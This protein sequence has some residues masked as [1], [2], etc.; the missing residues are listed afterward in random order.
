M[1]HEVTS[2]EK[3]CFITLTYDDENLPLR[4]NDPR[5]ILVKSDLQKFF[6]RMRKDLEFTYYACGEYGD[7]GSRPHF[8][9]IIFGQW[10]TK[11]QLAKY[12]RL[13]LVDV[14]TATEKSIRY[15]AGYVSKKLGLY[16]YSENERPAP[17]QISSQG[18]GF[19]WAKENLIESLAEGCITYQGSKLP[20][21]RPYVKMYEELFPEAV[22]G[23]NFRQSWQA[24]VALSDMLLEMCP[25]YGGRKFTEL[26]AE[27]KENVLIQLRKRGDAKDKLLRKGEEIKE[28]GTKL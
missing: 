18:L 22:E 14:G 24:D 26:T 2:A 23:F 8:H 21:P 13:G 15:V 11:E 28:Q 17:F 3:A 12:W 4:G 27:E 10:L 1:L 20:I 16:E 5:G 25:E 7:R 19:D 6:K 9:S